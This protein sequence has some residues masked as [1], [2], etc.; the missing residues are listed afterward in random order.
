MNHIIKTFFQAAYVHEEETVMKKED[1][2]EDNPFLD[3]L[4]NISSTTD[5]M[6]Q[7]PLEVLEVSGTKEKI[8]QQIIIKEELEEEN[9]DL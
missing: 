2:T 3:T 7:D 5:L 6:D 4:Q 9:Y 1:I 8:E